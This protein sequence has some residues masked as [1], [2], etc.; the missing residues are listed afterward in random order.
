M[1]VGGL[2]IFDDDTVDEINIP[3]QLHRINTIG[4]NK[5]SALAD[6]LQEFSDV[7]V[8]YLPERVFADTQLEGNIIISAVDSIAARKD[9]WQ[10][11]KRSGAGWYLD[12]RMASEY[13][14]LYLV[15]LND[16]AWYENALE[17]DTD[18][19]TLQEACTS[20]ATIFTAMF[21]A[22]WIGLAVKEIVTRSAQPGLWVHDI[23]SKSIL[24]I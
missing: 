9:I 15:D 18:E 17:Q 1:G 20:K 7:P 11:V 4:Q 13:F 21:A 3:T 2:L 12:A 8:A 23:K 6:T 24:I 14:K 22:G 10:A 19:N 5:A 16:P